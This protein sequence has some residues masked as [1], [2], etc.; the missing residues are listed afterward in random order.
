MFKYNYITYTFSAVTTTDTTTVST[1]TL[2]YHPLLQAVS[3]KLP[4]HP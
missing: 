1:P 2:L 3:A 4:P